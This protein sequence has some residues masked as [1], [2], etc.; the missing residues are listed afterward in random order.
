MLSLLASL[1]KQIK[2]CVFKV[3]LILDREKFIKT[4]NSYLTD[5]FHCYNLPFAVNE[6]KRHFTGHYLKM[7]L[8][9]YAA[10]ETCRQK[11]IE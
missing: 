1:V 5:I 3:D 7:S 8:F 9:R 2:I 10:A 4:A 11:T 6:K